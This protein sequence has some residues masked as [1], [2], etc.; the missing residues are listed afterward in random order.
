MKNANGEEVTTKPWQLAS[1][2][3]IRKTKLGDHCDQCGLSKPPLVLHHPFSTRSRTPE[4]FEQYLSCQETV[5][6]CKR[7]AFLWDIKGMNLCSKCKVH[8]KGLRFPYCFSCSKELGLIHP[9]IEERF[10]ITKAQIK[11]WDRELDKMEQGG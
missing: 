7:C 6:F 10:G 4:E 9:S 5:T 3:Q 8:Y 11:R 1:W 2:K